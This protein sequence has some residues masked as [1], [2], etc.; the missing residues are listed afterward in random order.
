[1]SRG[2]L[3][4]TAS[5]NR[6]RLQEL[7][8]RCQAAL[9]KLL[10]AYTD[11]QEAEVDPWTFA[12]EIKYFREAGR[13]DHDLRSLV[14][15]GYVEHRVETTARGKDRRT[16]RR[17]SMLTLTARTCVVLTESG[18]AWVR[19]VMKASRRRQ[20]PRART[21]SYDGGTL[22]AGSR[23]VKQFG[24]PAPSQDWLLRAFEQQHWQRCID[25]PPLPEIK[26]NRKRFLH[27]TIQNLNRDQ[28]HPL[29][30]FYIDATGRRV[31]W[32]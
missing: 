8:T 2:E 16:F 28:L 7:A 5:S 23:V 3:T 1:M 15:Q 6:R 14:L 12:V 24:R 30:R 29:I 21:I 31:C 13:A 9:Q 32:E 4:M 26:S 17:T 18:A 20:P 19:R 22:R 25:I 10:E 11:A 27:N